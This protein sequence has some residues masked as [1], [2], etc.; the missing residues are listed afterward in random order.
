MTIVIQRV[1][2]A[3]V[4]VEGKQTASYRSGLLVLI[5]VAAGDGED[6]ANE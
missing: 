3:H 1:S 6:D 4:T 2:R 5:G